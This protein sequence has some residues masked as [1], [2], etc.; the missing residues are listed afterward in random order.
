M[1][2]F[3]KTGTG[4]DRRLSKLIRNLL[5][6]TLMLALGCSAMRLAEAQV[7]ESA[8]AGRAFVWVGASGS[9]Y[10][11]QYGQRKMLGVTAFV[12]SDTI[13][14]FG[15]EGECRMLEFHQTQN[16]HAETYLGGVRYHFN[17]GRFQPYAKGLA[18]LGEFNF[19]Y[20]YA[21][22]SY[23]VIAPGAGIDYRLSRRVSVRAVDF[24]YQYW[25]QF[26]FGAMS[27]V[28]ISTGLR[29]RVF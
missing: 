22:G 26:T 24:E 11:L 4:D 14:H 16:V 20:N 25:P 5:R 6:I 3:L 1:K 2:K 28:G 27:S 23:L 29:F 21:H 12:D 8:D 9:G 10:T 17:V 7:A 18:G 13:R 19:T 15:I